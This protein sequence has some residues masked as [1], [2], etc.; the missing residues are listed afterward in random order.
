MR[1]FL[2]TM[3]GCLISTLMLNAQVSTGSE[4]LDE[5]LSNSETICDEVEQQLKEYGIDSKLQMYFDSKANEIVY[6]Y[7]FYDRA[8][9]DAMDMETA[10]MDSVK[11]MISAILAQDDTGWALEQLTADLKRTNIGFRYEVAYKDYIKKSHVSAS[12]IQRIASLLY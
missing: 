8:I 12:E 5:M 10:K 3:F 6:S 2:L 7:L 9:Y 11:G 4:I 1:R